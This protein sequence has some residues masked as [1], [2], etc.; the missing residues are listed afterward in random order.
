MDSSCL[1][2]LLRM[3]T[4]VLSLAEL[5][6]AGDAEAMARLEAV[7]TALEASRINDIVYVDTAHGVP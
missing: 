6:Q 4:A 2:A 7:A 3:T 5:A 1:P